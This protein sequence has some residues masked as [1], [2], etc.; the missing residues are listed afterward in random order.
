VNLHPV[1]RC[2]AFES[3]GF[4]TLQVCPDGVSAT[5]FNGGSLLPL[6]NRLGNCQNG[7]IRHFLLVAP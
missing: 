7:F 5:D 2:A 3:M 4:S 1:G 6:P